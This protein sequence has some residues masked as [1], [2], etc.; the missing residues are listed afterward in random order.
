MNPAPGEC[1]VLDE[2]SIACSGCGNVYRNFWLKT[3]DN[4][5]DFGFRYC[6]FCSKQTEE[7]AHVC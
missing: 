6:P 1:T 7:F 2:T 4:W 3:G 5:N